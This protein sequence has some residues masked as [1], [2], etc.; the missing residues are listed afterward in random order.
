MVTQ[1]IHETCFRRIN[2]AQDPFHNR[3]EDT[4]LRGWI[5]R[6]L[7]LGLAVGAVAAIVALMN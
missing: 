6:A 2:M 3:V 5:L 4:V 1:A 7:A